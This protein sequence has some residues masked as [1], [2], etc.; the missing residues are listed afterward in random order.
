[1]DIPNKLEEQFTGE[2]P[3]FQMARDE[4]SLK[5]ISD[6]F[7]PDIKPED[8]V[9]AFNLWKKNSI[10]NVASVAIYPD[11]KKKALAELTLSNVAN[12]A[13]RRFEKQK[14]LASSSPATYKSHID[15]WDVYAQLARQ[16]A[17]LAS[18]A[19]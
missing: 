8:V 2:S 9:S 4:F 5:F 17:T 18:K 6:E 15:T 7:K 12:F 1:M 14:E 19:S 13:R 10:E 3:L 11:F 16:S